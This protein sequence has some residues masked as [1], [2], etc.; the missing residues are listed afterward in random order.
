M[1]EWFPAS[2]K[3]PEKK[4]EYLVTLQGYLKSTRTVGIARWGLLEYPR[5]S[6]E[7]VW[8]IYDTE[9]GYIE[10]T[11]VMACAELPAPW[12]GDV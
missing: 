11:D 8:H 6:R 3:K 12:E 4:G 2:K 7:C 10:L 5:R 9:Y 1:V